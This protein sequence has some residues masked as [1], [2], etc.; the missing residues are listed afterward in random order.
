MKKIFILSL[1][2][3]F[4]FT[5][6]VFASKNKFKDNLY[7]FKNVDIINLVEASYEPVV[8]VDFTEDNAPVDRVLNQLRTLASKKG[9]SI[10]LEE[11]YSDKADVDLYLIV[12]KLGT[13]RYWRQP[14][15]EIVTDSEPV[16]VHRYHGR[17]HHHHHH[18]DEIVYVPVTH[19][20][21]HPGQWIMDSYVE[22]E[23]IVKDHKTNKVVY[24]VRDDRQR[25]STN[26]YSGMIKRI[27][28]DFLK[29]IK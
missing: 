8:D 5:G 2:L 11:N 12:H 15:T 29:D 26:D 22:I 10:L 17:H 16:V 6:P 27:C 25:Q 19:P 9:I 3:L 24:S 28:N 4:M 21:Y 23:F 14:W 7:D 1:L 20:V 13:Y 18:S